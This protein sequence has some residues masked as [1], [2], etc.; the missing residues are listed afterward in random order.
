MVAA[1]R[2]RSVRTT[3]P[4]STFN[5]IARLDTPTLAQMAMSLAQVHLTF[6][7]TLCHSAEQRDTSDLIAFCFS[8]SDSC[9]VNN[10]NCDENADC[11]HDTVTFAVICTCKNGYSNTGTNAVVRC[12]GKRPP[13]D[14]PS[15]R[16]FASLRR[17]IQKRAKSAMVAAMST[18]SVPMTVTDKPFDVHAK[19]DTSMLIRVKS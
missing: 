11:S 1:I 10:G 7:L 4:L 5:A 19:S 18:Q 17:L 2:M 8:L 9:K 6:T 14:V 3:K 13:P 15:A 16:S 12:T